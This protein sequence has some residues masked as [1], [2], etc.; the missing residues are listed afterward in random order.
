[1]KKKKSLLQKIQDT[2]T[3]LIENKEKIKRIRTIAFIVITLYYL[4]DSYTNYDLN[5]FL[6][7]EIWIGVYFS[8]L[9]IIAK[10]FHHLF[11]K[12][13]IH[14]NKRRLTIRYIKEKMPR[15]QKFEG[16][17]GVGKDST[18]NGIRKIFREDIIEYI[19]DKM[20]VYEIIC[21]PYDF[22][23]I[24]KYLDENIELF[25]TNAKSEFFKGFLLMLKLNNCFIK[26]N[27]EKNFSVDEH[28][29][30]YFSIQKN[31]NDPKHEKIKYK[32]NDGIKI[33]HYLSL[34]LKYC[35]YYIR[36]NYLDN[37]VITNQPTMETKLLP[38]NLF[39]TRFTNIQKSESEW[40]WPI[41][42][43]V[44]IIET[45]SDAFYPNVGLPKSENPM[46]T[47]YRNTK[48]FWRQFFKE[49]SVWINIGQ[50]ASRTQ[51]SIRELDHVFITVI[52]QSIIL[53]GEKRIY[54]LDK[55]LSWINFWLKKSIRKKAKEKQSR[56]RSKV[57]EKIKQLDNTGYIYVDLKI[58]RS[59]IP[60][61]AE[62][63]SLKKI[64][65]YDK[66]IF[67]NYTVK[68]CFHI[69][70]L[71]EGYNTEYM[72]AIA[73]LKARQSKLKWGGVMKWD[74]DLIMKKKHMEY[75]GYKIMDD[76]AGIDRV[77]LEK[78][79]KEKEKNEL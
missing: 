37:F 9:S 73:E 7:K 17:T 8:I 23:K 58:S 47:G 3:S 64:L 78:Q 39:S 62:E 24:R 15:S 33:Q 76:L 55:A 5:Y 12:W 53:G 25:L 63:M 56:R 10:I 27:Y 71:Y 31:P 52:E 13:F 19:E 14:E 72:E 42:G 41:D 16:P 45:E 49:K 70:D 74:P 77:K 60:G 54:F 20:E 61:S 2:Y 38:A 32:F 44:I 40:P 18:V 28:I 43:N 29:K 79:K 4:I 68:L 59:D 36:I 66:K 51:K 1:M 30:E 35:M 26:K 75:I 69:K 11:G 22:E 50:R 65:S 46:K 57:L 6:I 67:E 48:A 21:Y 34:V